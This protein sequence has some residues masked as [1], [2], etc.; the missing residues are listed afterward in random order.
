MFTSYYYITSYNPVGH[1][2]GHL[3]G[4][5]LLDSKEAGL[6]SVYTTTIL[7]ERYIWQ[8]IITEKQGCS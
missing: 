6:L 2:V 5:S 4:R 7:Y 1:L 3:V 8:S